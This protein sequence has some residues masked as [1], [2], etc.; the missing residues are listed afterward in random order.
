MDR[1][2]WTSILD[3]V[4]TKLAFN[5]G[6]RF[7]YGRWET[8]DRAEI[9]FISLNPGKAPG[10]T[11]MRAI[12]DE[13]GNTYEVEKDK[14]RSPITNQFL[15]LSN[16]LRRK[17]ADILTGVAVP[18]RSSDWNSLSKHQKSESIAL[19]R[20]F[21]ANP[22]TRPDLKLIIACSEDAAKLVIEITGAAFDRDEPACWGK[23]KLRRYRAS[24][25]K[26][27]VQLPHLSRYQLLSREN[28]RQAVR[29]ILGVE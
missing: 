7:V 14:T 16:L 3:Q 21:W 10:D 24:G 8:L 29:S 9:A 15:Q 11:D 18:F 17:P 19:G 26:V 6:Y 13:R 12:S 1:D 25:G 27:V 22:L 2:R 5:E 23:I 4:A 28:S 20:R